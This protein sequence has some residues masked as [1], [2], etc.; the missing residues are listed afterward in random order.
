MCVFV[1]A[2][3]MSV[4]IYYEVGHIASLKS[5]T[6]V[7]GFTHDW[8]LFLRGSDNN[9]ITRIIDKVIFNLHES[10]P[11]PKRGEHLIEYAVANL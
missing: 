4:K 11:K 6:T 7:E 8:E 9:N 10:F 2:G 3:T 1:V 5:K